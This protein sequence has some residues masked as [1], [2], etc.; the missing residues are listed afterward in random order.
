MQLITMKLKMKSDLIKL[1]LSFNWM[2]IL[3][4]FSI[5]NLENIHAQSF[6]KYHDKITT[7]YVFIT[8]AT[9]SI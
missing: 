2:L 5:I 9:Q 6:E 7:Q 1:N 3:V 8:A 4:L